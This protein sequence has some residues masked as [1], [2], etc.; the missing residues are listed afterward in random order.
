MNT[1]RDLCRDADQSHLCSRHRDDGIA[2]QSVDRRLRRAFDGA[3]PPS[4]SSV[5]RAMPSSCAFLPSWV[6][7]QKGFG[8]QRDGLRRSGWE[9]EAVATR[10]KPLVRADMQCNPDPPGNRRWR[11][12]VQVGREPAQLVKADASEVHWELDI[13]AAVRDGRRRWTAVRAGGPSRDRVVSGTGLTL[14]PV[15]PKRIASSSRADGLLCSVTWLCAG[16]MNRRCTPRR[17]TCTSA[18]L[19]AIQVGATRP[20]RTRCD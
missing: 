15:G 17:S 12:V 2:R 4:V 7:M 19:P 1:S 3:H 13:T 9:P 20:S 8:R 5:V 6:E 11:A 10:V 18:S 16:W 14:R